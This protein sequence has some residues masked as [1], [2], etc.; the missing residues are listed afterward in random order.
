MKLPN[1]IA[2]LKQIHEYS[3][4]QDLVQCQHPGGAQ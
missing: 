1:M 4:P 2:F 3:R